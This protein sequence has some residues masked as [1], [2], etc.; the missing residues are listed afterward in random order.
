MSEN[1]AVHMQSVLGICTIVALAWIFSEDR[2]AFRFRMVGAA[3]LLQMGI[4]LLLLKFPPARAMLL[5][6]NNIVTVLG[7]AT[8]AGAGFVFGYV[9]GGTSPFSVTNP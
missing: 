6:L 5:G 2:R 9:G 7:T 8:T 3:L 1:F 4:A